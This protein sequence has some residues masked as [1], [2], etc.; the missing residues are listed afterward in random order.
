MAATETNLHSSRRT[1]TGRRA[2][3]AKRPRPRQLGLSFRTWGG[4][5]AGAGRKAARPGGPGV[6]HRTRAPLASRH[7]VHVSLK[8]A[9]DLPSLRGPRL[10]TVL[11][12]CFRA[13][14]ERERFRIVLYAIQ[15]H[16]LHLVVEAANAVAL[17]R[18]LQ[19]LCIRVAKALNRELGRSGRVFVD[20]Y[21]ARILKSPR[22]VRS[23]LAYVL[24]NVARHT[25]QRGTTG[26]CGGLDPCSSAEHFDGWKE[27]G[28]GRL[29]AG[30][31]PGDSGVGP[32]VARPRTWLLG[33][34]WRR[35]GLISVDEVPGMRGQRRSSQD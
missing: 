35:H 22:Q 18:G 32:P 17:S 25:A 23:C 30:P 15:H 9:G 14:C 6:P 3:R 1:P 27:R 5:R 20:R 33:V 34:G 2:P 29:R 21:F 24:L 7:P 26:L 8:V 31:A 4:S 19:G 13:A 16:H 10:R 12:S 28:L 11:E